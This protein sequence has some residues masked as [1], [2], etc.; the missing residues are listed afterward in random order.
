VGPGVYWAVIRADD[1]RLIR[2]V[3]RLK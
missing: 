2:R 3:V 1:R